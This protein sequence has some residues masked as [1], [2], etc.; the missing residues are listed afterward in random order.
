M[1]FVKHVVCA[2]S[3]GVDSS[4]AALLLKRRGEWKITLTAPLSFFPSISSF[5]SASLGV[6]SGVTL[7][8]QTCVD[9]TFYRICEVVARSSLSTL[10]VL[11]YP[12]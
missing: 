11:S 10:V 5:V 3:G 7:F 1:G 9:I 4:V 2:M 8:Q 6:T 12:H